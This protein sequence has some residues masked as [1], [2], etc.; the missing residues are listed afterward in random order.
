MYF[1][2][3]GYQFLDTPLLENADL[4]L[5]KAGGELAVR[6]YAFTDPGGNRVVL[7]PEFT[8]SVVRGYLEMAEP[9]PTPWRVQYSGPV[10]RHE[11][12]IE[13]RQF[14]QSGAELIGL[15]DVQADAEVLEIAYLSLASLGLKGHSLI[16]G[17]AGVYLS[18]CQQLDVSERAR[19]FLLASL[20]VL[21]EGEAGL[22]RVLQEAERLHLISSGVASQGENADEETYR[23]VLKQFL[24]HT[25]AGTLGQRTHAEVEKRML[26]K[27]RGEQ[28]VRVRQTFEVAAELAST[29]G[30]TLTQ[31]L[32]QARNILRRHKLSTEA[33]GRLEQVVKLALER[34][35]PRNALKIDL[36]LAR[37]IAYYTG[38]VFEVRH[39]AT[40]QPLG[41]GGRYDG[42][43]HEL[44]HDSDVPALGFAFTL[45][46]LV[47]LMGAGFTSRRERRRA[48]C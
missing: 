28:P 8:A 27:L 40:I 48:K 10:F 35:I 21:S 2:Q 42:L 36:S 24:S 16:I 32:A 11:I 22:S 38:F 45:E 17:D 26:D 34:S 39:P 7:R 14:T 19:R 44:G 31:T 23:A 15:Q 43:I 41:G 18:L 6:M 1:E 5:R 13:R 33:V 29:K 12:D 47:D 30:A 9:R 46:N 20:P 3:H 25:H 4:F 37:G